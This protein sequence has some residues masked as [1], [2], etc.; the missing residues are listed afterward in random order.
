MRLM[1]ARMR[2]DGLSGRVESAYRGFALQCGVFAWSARRQP[3][4][5]CTVATENALAGHSQHQLGTTVDMFTSDWRARDPRTGQGVFRDG[6][7]C[8][9]G[10]VW[11]DEH[12]WKY[13]FI[14]PYPIHPD[15]RRPGSRCAVRTDEEEPIN[16]K[17]GFKHEPWHL[18]YVGVA[19]A[20]Q[21]HEA[22][23]ASGPG[24]ANEIALEQ[25]LRARS[26]LAGDTDLPLCDGC[27]CGACATFAEDGDKTPCGD[28]SL[29][30][31]GYGRVASPVEEPLIVRVRA[32][33]GN[34]D[35]ATIEVAVHAPAHTPTQPPVVGDSGPVYVAGSS[36]EA[37]VPSPGRSPHGYADLPGAWRVGIEPVPCGSTRWPWRASLAKPE[38]EPTWN[39]ANALLPANAGD[40]VVRVRVAMP[41]GTDRVRVSLLEGESEHGTVEVGLTGAE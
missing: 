33:M 5:F 18:R 24:T 27:N 31:D 7:G 15:D 19:A 26:G 8:T 14:I 16:P 34:A 21:Y 11:L 30:L 25:W 20:A 23:L 22:W 35:L 9:A 29:R 39:R 3:G 10:G 38:L 32:V 12:S 4:G 1:L 17:T 41:A 2:D 37:L 13:G 6:F 36:F 28:A 40:H